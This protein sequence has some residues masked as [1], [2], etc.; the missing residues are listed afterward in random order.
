M[1]VVCETNAERGAVD[2]AA[3]RWSRGAAAPAEDDAPLSR[4]LELSEEQKHVEELVMEGR[5][6]FFT[7]SA[8]VGKAC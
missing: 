5:N 2:E 8:G 4:P 6:V 7:G 3:S 1:V